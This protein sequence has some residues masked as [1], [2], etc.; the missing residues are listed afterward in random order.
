MKRLKHDL[1][2]RSRLANT[3]FLHG[4]RRFSNASIR[5]AKIKRPDMSMRIDIARH[6]HPTCLWDRPIASVSQFVD[7]NGGDLASMASNCMGSPFT[8]MF[9]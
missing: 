3:E 8:H 9:M 2:C 1:V 6:M 4:K 7:I 5:F